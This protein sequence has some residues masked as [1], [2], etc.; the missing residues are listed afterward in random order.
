M[1]ITLSDYCDS[2]TLPFAFVYHVHGMDWCATN[3]PALKTWL[4]SDTAD[5][6]AYKKMLFGS[7][8]NDGE[9][10]I[11]YSAWDVK[12]IVNLDN[13]VGNQKINYKRDKGIDVGSWSVTVQGGELGYTWD[14]SS[15]EC[16][17]VMGLDCQPDITSV[18]AKSAVLSRDFQPDVTFNQ[19]LYW[20]KSRDN[21]LYTWINAE[22]TAG[23]IPYVWVGSSC[24]SLFD[25]ASVDGDEYTADAVACQ[26]NTPLE[27]V[28]NKFNNQLITI[29]NFPQSIAGMTA[30]LYGIPFDV[31]AG[32]IIG[33]VTEKPFLLRTGKV[34]TNIKANGANQF[35]ISNSGFT[36]Q[37][38]YESVAS[39]T[40]G[41]LSGFHFSRN[42]E[43]ASSDYDTYGRKQQPHLWVFETNNSTITSSVVQEGDFETATFPAWTTGPLSLLT[44]GTTNPFSGSQYGKL[45]LDTA[46]TE[47]YIYQSA[48]VVG[49][50]YRIIRGAVRGDA[51]YGYPV[52]RDGASVTIWSGTTLASSWTKIPS[53]TFTAQTTQLRL[54]TDIA[55]GGGVGSFSDWDDIQLETCETNTA[56]L[57]LGNMAEGSSVRYETIA[58]LKQAV[59]TELNRATTANT[60]DCKYQLSNGDLVFESPNLDEYSVQIFGPAAFV[61]GLGYINAID[62]NGSL[63]DMLY[64][65]APSFSINRAHRHGG[66]G[67][68]SP[69]LFFEDEFGIF[70][71]K[72]V[73][74]W[75]H[76]RE[77]S[78]DSAN[79]ITATLGWF[80]HGQLISP[81]KNYSSCSY[82][83]Q[84]LFDETPW[85]W[86]P[87][88]TKVPEDL[89]ANHR[90]YYTIES[91]T[92]FES[93][94]YITFGNNPYPCE[95]VV[96]AVGS[97]GGIKYMTCNYTT[98][99][100][101][102]NTNFTNR[103]PES[104]QWFSGWR[105][106]YNSGQIHPLT[107]LA[108]GLEN[109][110]WS[111]PF[112]AQDHTDISATDPVDIIK[113][114]L[115]DE[116]TDVGVPRGMRCTTIN[117]L[118]GYHDGDR[119]LVDWDKF[120]SLV[121]SAGL[122]GS[123]YK[124]NVPDDSDD[125]TTLPEVE[126]LNVLDTINGICMTHGIKQ[127]WEY[128]EVQRSWW[129]TFKQYW[130]DSIAN[131]SNEGRVLDSAD[132]INVNP[133]G[134]AGGQWLYSSINLELPRVDGDKEIFNV[135]KAVGRYQHSIGAK[136]LTIK[137]KLTNL[138]VSSDS[139][140]N[141]LINILSNYLNTFAA[142]HYQ[143][144]VNAK[145]STITRFVVGGGILVDLDY[146]LYRPQ[147][148]R[149]YGEQ[150]GNVEMLTIGFGP[151]ARVTADLLTSAVS[152]TGI[153]PSM[154]IDT[155]TLS[156]TILSVTGLATTNDDSYFVP[157]FGGMTDLAT[158]GCWSWSYSN[159]AFKQKSCTCG[160][161]KIWIIERDQES[162][163]DSGASR[164]VWNG[165]ITQPTSTNLTNG[166]CLITL[167]DTTNFPESSAGGRRFV[168]IF[169]DRD[170]AGLQ[171][172]QYNLYGWLGDANGTVTDSDSNVT[173]AITIGG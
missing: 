11:D 83:Y 26:F 38:K 88:V 63:Q 146:I 167:S 121:A 67:G 101:T 53:L 74:F 111:D 66:A 127:C 114:L 44:A 84:W 110:D 33:E 124:I 133:S 69:W 156:D 166:T 59:V 149:R 51:N 168:I 40:T 57:W 82:Y 116:S 153:A 42:T 54:Y 22:V 169:A 10:G 71:F 8:T 81:I 86:E 90:F 89:S 91:D 60:I 41:H 138:P 73:P 9:G 85:S 131:A 129:L 43:I 150:Y 64:A 55:S 104:M 100:G 3:S 15:V 160:N 16:W 18:S 19:S 106:A 78:D 68:S 34:Q 137:D 118:W 48:L 35:K 126:T 120:T 27:L 151:Q 130:G 154:F 75:C 112:V 21:G 72:K 70:N 87:G 23:R 92:N 65:R 162:L 115:G 144:K 77:L 76:L 30:S 25:G 98:P 56:E 134:Q 39:K 46:A 13:N 136:K 36:S 94:D 123:T 32:D 47:A 58:E 122:D 37:F 7:V 171:P 113:Q 145:L 103:M 170:N 158:F 107:V 132:D 79:N 165:T 142:V 159:N 163:T 117:N 20:D 50:R 99:A 135:S 102:L 2:H 61:C 62:Y 28:H 155:Y 139:A 164:N 52:L 147:G 14:R 172:C 95:A 109:Q 108:L 125:T 152:R 97:L 29:T 1:T 143:Q 119:E 161:Y 45:T 141:T 6:K 173:Q 80:E 96:S 105:D 93:G 140:K 157:S 17:G 4:D 128:N 49:Q 12:C 148:K 31:E 24:L 5:V